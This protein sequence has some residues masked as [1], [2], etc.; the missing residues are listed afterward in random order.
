M[1][2]GAHLQHPHSLHSQQFEHVKTHHGEAWAV[3]VSTPPV[4]QALQLPVYEK[5]E[6]S[7]G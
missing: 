5:A 4:L 6:G 3:D 1:S 2:L 7:L